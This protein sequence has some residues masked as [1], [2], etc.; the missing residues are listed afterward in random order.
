M[1][2]SLERVLTVHQSSMGS[3]RLPLELQQHV[4]SYLDPKSFWAARNVC[5]WWRFASVD[6]VTLA[7]QLRKLPILP[8]ADAGQLTPREM[9]DLFAEASYTLM[10]GMQVKR[11][12]DEEGT[13]SAPQRQGFFAGPRVTA[14]ST[15]T[16]TVTIND[17]MIALFDTAGDTPR[18]LTQR[19]LNDL[20]ETVG[21]GPW[22]KVTPS[23][24]HELALSSDGNLLAIAQERTIQIYDLSAEPDSFTVNEYI[25]SAAGHY[26]CGL[27]FEQ[28]DHVLRVRLSGKGAVLYLG[29]PPLDPESTSERRQKADIWHWKSK[30]GLRHVFLDSTLLN[31]RDNHTSGSESGPTDPDARLSGIQ[32]LRPFEHGYLLGAQKHGRKESSHYV[33]AHVQCSPASPSTSTSSSSSPATH[34]RESSPSPHQAAPLTVQPTTVTLLARLESFLSAWDYFLNGTSDDAGSTG[35]AAGSAGMGRWENMPSCHEHHPSYALSPDMRLLVLAE[36]DKKRIRPVQLSQ[37]FVYQLPG[38]AE[39][40]R[41]L[42]GVWKDGSQQQEGEE[43]VGEEDEEMDAGDEVSSEREVQGKKHTVAPIPLCLSTIQGAVNELRLVEEEEGGAS[44]C[45]GEEAGKSG[46]K[47]LVLTALAWDAAK[48]WTFSQMC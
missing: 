26:I 38:E 25:P 43:E 1:D 24:Y 23:S 22:L 10:L 30:A 19:P 42:R 11:G 29:T 35:T 8:P 31:L 18:L 14:T 21:N 9:H 4:F 46:G 12:A 5:K 48:K 40:G 33:L 41:R 15:G 34:S 2:N 20:K 28:N 39:L 13:M 47:S 27:D 37:L 7:R 17:R 44:S 45:H 16:R 3:T 32:L 6:A 36:R